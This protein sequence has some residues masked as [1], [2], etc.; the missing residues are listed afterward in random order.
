MS[1]L[2]STKKEIKYN[3]NVLQ[4]KELCRIGCK[5][6]GVIPTILKHHLLINLWIPTIDFKILESS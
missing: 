2:Q 5:Y 4:V 6:N 1:S 3:E